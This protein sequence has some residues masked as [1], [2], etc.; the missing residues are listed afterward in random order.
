MFKHLLLAGLLL[1]VGMVALTPTANA[2]EGPEVCV[3]INDAATCVDV[4]DA[5][6]QAVTKKT[7]WHCVD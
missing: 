1:S 2:V 7:G 3:D 4:Y 6:C 5:L